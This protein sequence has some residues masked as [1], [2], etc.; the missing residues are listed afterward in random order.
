MRGGDKQMVH[1]RKMT[2][3]LIG[4]GFSADWSDNASVSQK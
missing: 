3:K 2:V 1:C 4:K